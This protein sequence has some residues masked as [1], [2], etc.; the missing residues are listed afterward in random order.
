M[1]ETEQVSNFVT[2]ANQ[3]ASQFAVDADTY[4]REGAFPFEHY[5]ALHESGYLRLVV[6]TE[7]GGASASLYEMVRAQE[8]LA[9][10]DGSTAMA[11][12]MTVQVIGRLREMATWPEA[13]FA[14]VCRAIVERGALVYSVATEADL[15]SPSRGGAPQTSATPVAGGWLINGRKLFVSM[16]PALTFF[17]TSV[18]LPPSDDAPQG[19]IAQAIVTGDSPGLQIENTWSDSLSL[20][21]S[22]SYDVVY[23][24]V[25]V[26][27]DLLVDRVAIGA[28]S[29]PGA[30]VSM[31]W[32]AL[33]LSAV[34]LG[35]GQAACDAVCTYARERVP[36]A[37]GKP[38][39][40]LPN[41]QRRV[42]EAHAQLMA[43]R[44]VLHDVAR[45]WSEVPEQRISMAPQIAMAKYLATN[46]AVAAADQALRVAGGFALT[47][48]L[49]LERFYR[50]ARAG[51]THPPQDDAA[52]EMIGKALMGV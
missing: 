7:Y 24:D 27:D 51:L 4:D 25:F 14:H 35:I 50:D 30:P 33:T 47:R 18:A 3:L 20:R 13:T 28:P 41:I 29:R 11:V 39:A 15:G 37:L 52:L 8:A 22:G 17:I 23:T 45:T 49:P 48:R 40:T 36:T 2:I 5:R 6:P 46:A 12:D 42:G 31:A 9:R 10:G 44:L 1:S 34:Y 16:A 43:A 21:A 26:P 32:F 38:I 19:A